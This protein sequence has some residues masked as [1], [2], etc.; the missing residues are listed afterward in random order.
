MEIF[1]YCWAGLLPF[2]RRKFPLLLADFDMNEALV[3]NQ[4]AKLHYNHKLVIRSFV[5]WLF[6]RRGLIDLL[7]IIN[8]MFLIKIVTNAAIWWNYSKKREPNLL[9][10]NA[11]FLVEFLSPI[12]VTVEIRRNWGHVCCVWCF[13][14]T[15]LGPC[16]HVNIKSCCQKYFSSNKFY[17][18]HPL[19]LS[20]C[21]SLA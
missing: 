7:T 18:F 15:M 3:T 5:I 20:L 13:I 4:V 12:V 10:L 14:W 16:W 11:V 17:L 19:C 1:N 6:S 2:T 9:S 21:N 8:W